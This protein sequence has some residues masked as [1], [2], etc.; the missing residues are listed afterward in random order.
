M[1]KNTERLLI[2]G[3]STRAAQRTPVFLF[4]PLF[5]ET[6]GKFRRSFPDDKRSDSALRN[7]A[8]TRRNGASQRVRGIHIAE[9]SSTMS[10]TPM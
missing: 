2:D 5:F 1:Q 9:Y 6:G 8:R 10:I 3:A 7:S 4:F